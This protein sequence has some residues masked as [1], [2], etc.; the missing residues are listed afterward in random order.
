MVVHPSTGRLVAA[1]IGGLG[2]LKGLDP[3]LQAAQVVA[4]LL[5]DTDQPRGLAARLRK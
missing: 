1:G 3:I 2:L 4:R 5:E